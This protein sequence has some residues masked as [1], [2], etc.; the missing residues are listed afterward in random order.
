MT[1]ATN[2]KNVPANIDIIVLMVWQKQ[3]GQWKLVARQAARL[4]VETK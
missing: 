3:N 4:P 2:N 1:G